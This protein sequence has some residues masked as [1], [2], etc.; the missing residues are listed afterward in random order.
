MIRRPYQSGLSAL[1]DEFVT[2]R[3]AAGT[4]SSTYNDNL[5]HFDRFCK[6]N[7]PGC[8]SLVEGMLK[9]CAPRSTER[10]NSCR[11]RTTVIWNF[12]DYLRATGRTT[13]ISNRVKYVKEMSFMP[14]IFT[15]DELKRFFAECDDR[16]LESRKKTPNKYTKLNAVE[17]PVFFRLLRSTGLR[18]CEARWLR[19]EDIDFST[20]VVTI[21]KSKGGGQHRIVLHQSML[22]LL[23]RYDMVISG[24]MPNRSALFP[25][26]DGGPHGPAW[27]S[28]HFRMIWSRVSNVPARV[29]DFRHLYATENISAIEGLGCEMNG[30][31]LF[32]SRSMGHSSPEM[33]CSYFHYIPIL[34]DKIEERSSESFRS[35]L[36]NGMTYGEE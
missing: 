16:C 14:H 18:T 20:G 8:S 32:L 4:W 2:S 23:I 13:V 21:R 5:H 12:V 35:L 3:K 25:N 9:W 33:T 36:Q 24:I 19:D 30:R 17:L 15:E 7:Y 11:V 31:L 27:E 28:A 34:H 1:M 22:E 26:V 29:Y 10:A 6:E